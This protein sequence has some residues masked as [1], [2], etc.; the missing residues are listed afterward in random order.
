[1]VTVKICSDPKKKGSSGI[2][3][4]GRARPSGENSGTAKDRKAIGDGSDGFDGL[5]PRQCLGG[6]HRG[7]WLDL[8]FPTA[9]GRF[10]FPRG[11]GKDSSPINEERDAAIGATGTPPRNPSDP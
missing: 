10:G 5:A 7:Q 11:F 4:V 3:G 6:R 9:S 1:M 2:S 8:P